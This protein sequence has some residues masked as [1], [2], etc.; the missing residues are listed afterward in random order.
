MRVKRELNIVLALI[1]SLILWVYVFGQSNSTIKTTIK[2][3]PISIENASEL[4]ADGLAIGNMEAQTVSIT[5]SGRRVI[6]SKLTQN[7]FI[8]SC[9]ASGLK[10]GVTTLRLNVVAPE[11]VTVSSISHQSIK[12]E[13]EEEDTLE[14]DIIV[15]VIND[16]SD[17]T[18]PYVV[19]LS[20]EK[21]DVTGAK[22]LIKQVDSVVATLDTKKV[23]NE[24]QAFNSAL[25]P[26]DKYGKEINGLSLSVQNVSITAK[27]ANKKTVDLVTEVIGE[28]KAKLGRT[29]ECPKAVTIK[30]DEEALSKVDKII[31]EPLDISNVYES[32]VIPFKL[33]MPD[34]V[35]LAA[36][37]QR[38]G[39][40]ITV[41]KAGIKEFEFHETDIIANGIEEG[42]TVTISKVTIKV[43]VAGQSTVLNSLT[44]DDINLSIDSTGLY[45]GTYVV[46]LNISCNKETSLLEADVKEV[47]VY[48]E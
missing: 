45:W 33:E 17:D 3:I 8:V 2:D 16:N 43:S 5:F 42:T 31:A 11:D 44:K 20:T 29:A 40:T 32:T 6:T 24:M 34:G 47:E 23:T 9:D 39:A 13:V 46:D 25:V 22:S 21:V 35:M 7:D 19:Q 12:V 36:D 14:K 48:V 10:E 26:V 15:D 41:D 37:S 28:D 30:G 27:L 1:I 18:E 4:S 38:V